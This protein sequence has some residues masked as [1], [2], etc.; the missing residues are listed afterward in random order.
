LPNKKSIT[1]AKHTG[2]IA[3]HTDN[4]AKHTGKSVY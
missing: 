3:K 2:N 4:I 1:I